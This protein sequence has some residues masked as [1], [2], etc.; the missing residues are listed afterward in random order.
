MNA[1]IVTCPGCGTKNRI[2]ES[3]Q[4]QGPRCG[5][6]GEKLDIRQQARPVELDDASLESFVGSAGLPVVLDFYSPTCGP[7]QSL[8]PLLARLAG[9][10]LGRVII[11]KIDT[12]RNGAG[13]SRYGIRGVPTLVF[14]R[15]GKEID[16]LVGLPDSGTLRARLESVAV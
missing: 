6:C 13:A 4:H 15:H 8:A 1:L 14:F 9:E 16:R 7:C 3:R 2:A 5:R 12:S 11:A 10:Y